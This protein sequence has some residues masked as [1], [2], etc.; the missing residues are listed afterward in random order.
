VTEIPSATEPTG[1]FGDPFSRFRDPG[2]NLWWVYRHGGQPWAGEGKSAVWAG[3]ASAT[4]AE[5]W[6]QTLA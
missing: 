2:S 5:A 3:D 4:D 6:E 1:F